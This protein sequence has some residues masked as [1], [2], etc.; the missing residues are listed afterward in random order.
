MKR[1]K[2]QR[3]IWWKL[4]KVVEIVL[5]CNIQRDQSAK[6]ADWCAP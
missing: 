6:K 4:P 5:M 1:T 3:K 2:G